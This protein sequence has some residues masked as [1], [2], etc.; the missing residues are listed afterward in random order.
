MTLDGVS[1]RKHIDNEQKRRDQRNQLHDEVVKCLGVLNEVVVLYEGAAWMNEAE[2]EVGR[3]R[4]LS[5]SS[6]P[7]NFFNWSQ[8]QFRVAMRLSFQHQ[9]HC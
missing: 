2:I 8:T 1:T 6:S 5:Q 4:C 7:L 9:Y 3:T